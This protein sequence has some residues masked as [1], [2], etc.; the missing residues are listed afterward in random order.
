MGVRGSAA[1]SIILY[2]LDITDIDPLAHDLVFERFLNAERREMPDI[3]M[4]F[5]DNRRDE[6]I[7]YVGEKYG[8][9]RVAQIITFG[10]LGAK[11]AIRDTGRALGL[12]FGDADRVARLVPNQLNIT[13]NDALE[14]SQEL[15]AVYDAEPDVAQASG[16]GAQAGGGRPPR[17]YP[18]RRRRHRA[19]AA[20][21]KRAPANAP[22]A[23]RTTIA[24][25]SP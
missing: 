8:H 14:G 2:C 16:P 24:T 3:D 9:D 7:R 13:L 15:R 18:R 22:C 6:V 12:S 20:D 11:A 10:T 4:D 5:A 23:R 19:R 25:P 1:A 17:R 21:R